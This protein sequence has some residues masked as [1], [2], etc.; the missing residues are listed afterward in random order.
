MH[1]FQSY[2]FHL[3][4]SLLHPSSI[5]PIKRFND[6]LPLCKDSLTFENLHDGKEDN[7]HIQAERQTINVIHIILEAFSEGHKKIR[8]F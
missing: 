7:L 6:G 4:S 8:P 3:T 5:P 1:I 2:I